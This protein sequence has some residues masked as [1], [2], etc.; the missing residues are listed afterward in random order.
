MKNLLGQLILPLICCVTFFG[1]AAVS[2]ELSKPEPVVSEDMP[3]VDTS[4]EQETIRRSY[5]L[6][7]ADKQIGHCVLGIR[8]QRLELEPGIADPMRVEMLGKIYQKAAIVLRD[9]EDGE[10]ACEELALNVATIAE[11]RE[12]GFLPN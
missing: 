11:V 10:M 2:I 4:Q 8:T 3:V 7:M 6:Y 1:G 5:P 12:S 9:V